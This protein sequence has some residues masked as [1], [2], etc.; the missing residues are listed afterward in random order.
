[1]R[2][3]F[4]HLR[5]RSGRAASPR[6]MT[7]VEIM[8][9]IT[10][11][12]S[13]MGVVGFYVFGTLN[14]AQSKNARMGI[15]KLSQMCQTYSMMYSSDSSVPDSLDQ[16]T[17]GQNPLVKNKSELKDPWGNKYVYEKKG[18]QNYVIYSAGPDGQPGTKDDVHPKDDG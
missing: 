8:I 14:Q 1:M 15:E 7:L 9:V 13:I 12:A 5:D 16:L 18:A 6:G 3:L 10:I 4:K 17:Q 2:R 11:M